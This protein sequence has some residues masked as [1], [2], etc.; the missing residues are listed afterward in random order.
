MTNLNKSTEATITDETAI[1]FIPCYGHPFSVL[2]I[3]PPWLKKEGWIKKSKT[4]SRQKFR[5]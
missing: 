2:M 4:K 1:G 3:D 5:L